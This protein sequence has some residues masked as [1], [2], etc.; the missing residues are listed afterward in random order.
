MIATL[1]SLDLALGAGR[2]SAWGGF[3]LVVGL[4]AAGDP[5]QIPRSAELVARLRTLWLA[6]AAL[7]VFGALAT[8]LLQSA[9]QAGAGWSDLL[10][11]RL[12]SE[13]FGDGGDGWAVV[14]R[15]AAVMVAVTLG[16]RAV[17]RPET[18]GRALSANATA[19]SVV[20]GAVASALAGHAGAVSGGA[21]FAVFVGAVHLTAVGA[22][23]GGIAVLVTLG[24]G[25]QEIEA[26]VARFSRFAGW[27][28]PVAVVSGP[29]LAWFV[30]GDVS[31]IGDD[32]YSRW[33]IVKVLLVAAVLALAGATRL[34]SRA[35]R[36]RATVRGMIAELVVASAILSVVSGLAALDPAAGTAQVQVVRRLVNEGMIAVVEVTDARVGTTVVHFYFTPQGG[37][38]ESVRTAG[39]TLSRTDGTGGET[40][41]DLVPSGANHFTAIVE[42]PSTGAWNLVVVASPTTA[43]EVSFTLSF[44]VEKT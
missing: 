36:R 14:V 27:L 29:V 41:L 4:L 10:D 35:G 1:L 34:A 13:T 9:S 39:A 38:L 2:W 22:W 16:L 43:A 11:P 31:S 6:A 37:S 32:A 15:L 3:T 21:V 28:V 25:G 12:L 5:R 30:V 44:I 18:A 7:S 8:V 40:P 24:R 20:A 19:L 42:L 33:L 17:S 26:V 23:F